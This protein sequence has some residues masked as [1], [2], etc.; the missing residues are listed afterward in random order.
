M[1]LRN[2]ILLTGVT[3]V[4]KHKNIPGLPEWVLR[5]G[6]LARDTN[7]L[8]ATKLIIKAIRRNR[9]DQELSWCST[10]QQK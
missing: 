1:L 9:Q 2:M 3:L 6:I 4:Q 10:G 7:L 5:Y 8:A